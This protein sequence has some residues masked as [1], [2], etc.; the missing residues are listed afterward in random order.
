MSRGFQDLK[1][2]TLGNKSWKREEEEK[3]GVL[4]SSSEKKIG[5]GKNKARQNTRSDDED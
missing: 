4:R 5:P 2:S 1:S 3:Q